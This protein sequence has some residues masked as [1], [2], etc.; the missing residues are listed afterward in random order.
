MLMFAVLQRLFDPAK[1]EEL[2]R[3]KEGAGKEAERRWDE[4]WDEVAAPV[5]GL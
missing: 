5:F 3:L 1:A 2:K 4:T